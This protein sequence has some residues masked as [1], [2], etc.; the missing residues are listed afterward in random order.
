MLAIVGFRARSTRRWYAARVV[1]AVL[2]VDA[3]AGCADR[4]AL[5]A[6]PAALA[7]AA[8]ELLDRL[9]EDPYNYFRFINHEWTS[10]VCEVFGADLAKQP[11]VQ[12]HGDAHIEQYALTDDAW[13]LDDFDD[14]T[15][16]PAL[17]DISR[18]LGSIDLAA[19]RR[20]WSGDRDRLFDRFFEGYRRGLSQ[21]AYHPAKPDIVRWVRTKNPVP[22]RDAFFASAETKMVPMSEASMKGLLASMT[23]F[24]RLVRRERPELPEGY[25]QVIHA[26]W[27]QMGIGSAAI[28]KIL[29]RVR[30][31]SDDPEDDELLEAKALRALKGLG[32]LEAPK[33]R[34]A[35][36]VIV[37][38]QQVG[39]LR[40][41]ILVAGPEED[42]PEMTIAGEHLRNWW[43]R[44]W[45]P[46]YREITLDDLRSVEDLSDLVYDSGVQLGSGSV[47]DGDDGSLR[48]Q[49]LSAI[50]AL[51]PRLRTEAKTLVEEMMRGW[52]Q[53]RQR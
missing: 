35:F 27:L 51:Q 5:T 30:G 44:S 25:F 26:G 38:S 12:L 40:H 37:G 31:P 48:S 34:P 2:V 22:S 20:G 36:R 7:A 9:R 33:S 10:R 14:S 32:C 11:I 1:L 18:F 41:N 28:R 42:I 29:M 3:T 52:G 39:R 47:H 24:S 46:S 16:G 13:G 53:L 6:E 15:R 43:V 21:V 19:R 23:V 45:E 49:S 17:V 4:H 8:P 50:A